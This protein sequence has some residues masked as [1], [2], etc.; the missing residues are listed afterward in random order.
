MNSVVRCDE[1]NDWGFSENRLSH[2]IENASSF[3]DAGG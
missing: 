1:I 3:E 2:A